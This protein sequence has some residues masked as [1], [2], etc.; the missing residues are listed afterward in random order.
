MCS[1]EGC[2]NKVGPGNSIHGKTYCSEHY[3]PA[4]KKHFLEQYDKWD[5]ENNPSKKFL[6]LFSRHVESVYYKREE[7]MPESL[8][9]GRLNDRGYNI[10]KTKDGLGFSIVRHLY[11]WTRGKPTQ[12]VNQHWSFSIKE[13]QL[14]LLSENPVT[15]SVQREE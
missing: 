1:W 12:E 7:E 4:I 13:D 2:T 3:G 15:E 9:K 14:K 8:S 11:A 5:G 10:K 6:N